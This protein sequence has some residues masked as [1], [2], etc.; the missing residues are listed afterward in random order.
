MSLACNPERDPND[1]QSAELLT[2]LERLEDEG[3][4]RQNT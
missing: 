4:S 1:R 2:L 3:Y